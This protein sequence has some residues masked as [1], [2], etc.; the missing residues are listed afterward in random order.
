[1]FYGRTNFM[2][3]HPFE[4][5]VTCVRGTE[6]ILF[7][8]L[9]SLK[10]NATGPLRQKKGGVRLAISLEEVYRICLHARTAMRVYVSVLTA[11]V[12]SLAE[13]HDAVNDVAWER[14]FG[15]DDTFAIS[16]SV[17]GWDPHTPNYISLLVKD[18][19][20]DRFNERM[21]SRPSVSKDHPTL[22][23]FVHLENQ[24][25]ELFLD[26]SGDPLF[27]RGYRDHSGGD[28][29][30]KEPLAA[31]MIMMSGWTADAPLMDPFCGS[32]TLLLEAA[33]I[34]QRIAP[35]LQRSFGIELWKN[36]LND[37]WVKQAREEARALIREQ[38]LDMTGHDISKDQLDHAKQNAKKIGVMMKWSPSPIHMFKPTEGFVVTNPPYDVRMEEGDTRQDFER[39]TEA[40]R[41]GIT[42]ISLFD[43]EKEHERRKNISHNVNAT[44]PSNMWVKRP[45]KRY[46]VMNGSL[47]CEVLVRFPLKP[48]KPQTT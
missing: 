23:V 32:G 4:A 2:S 5:W 38:P 6:D 20:V 18:A 19:M 42:V 24:N 41:G 1:M 40:F 12:F 34:Q 36:A 39:V 25:L 9:S 13:L 33:M 21:G 17:T 47:P 48:S 27:K 35:G 28:A 43:Q 45:H 7:A 37:A 26:A 16:S 22:R 11:E 8:E 15:T 30:L 44:P 3:T 46:R 29:P 31:A 14:W 10:L